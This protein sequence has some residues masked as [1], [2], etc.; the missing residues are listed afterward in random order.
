VAWF[1][2]EARLSAEEVC[3]DLFA[4]E[5]RRV[6]KV[7]FAK[8]CPP[9]FV[10]P[11]LRITKGAFSKRTERSIGGFLAHCDDALPD[12]HVRR[13]FRLACMAVL[14]DVSYTRKDGQYLR[15]DHRGRKGR[16]A[17][18]FDKGRIPPFAEAVRQKLRQIRDDVSAERRGDLLPR[19]GTRGPLDMRMGS[20]LDLLP[21]IPAESVDFILTSPPYCNR[22]D[23]TRTYALELAFLGHTD[24]DVRDLRQR[25]LSCTVENREKAEQLRAMYG[26]LGRAEVFQAVEAL[27]QKQEA[28]QGILDWLDGLRKVGRLN[29]SNIP[30]M[31]RNYF[32]EMAFVVH[33]LA[34][35]VRPG[36][37]IVMVNDNVRYA[38]REVPVDL[39]LSDLAAGFGLCV[40]R[41]WT[42]PRAKGNSSQQMGTHGR[43][44]L[45]KCVYVWRKP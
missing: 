28:L 40:D 30:R 12:V 39:I 20:C 17:R 27:F 24:N 4:E 45:R 8:L 31:V 10:F 34:R 19:R 36:A 2:A 11:H 3:P 7:D 22:Y 44:E 37:T 43:R 5:V 42:L 32:Y 18:P 35:I 23:Y 26:R 41:I 6:T 1:V 14:E 38:G 13:L 15:W 9:D 29:N 16:A 33:E 25:L 21:D